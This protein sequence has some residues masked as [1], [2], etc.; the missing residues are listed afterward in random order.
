MST[1]ADKRLVETSH[2]VSLDAAQRHLGHPIEVG[3][4]ISRGEIVI[5]RP[6]CRRGQSII[7]KN[8]KYFIRG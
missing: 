4:K 3:A 7:V 5:G 6:V 8:D 2:F 1:K